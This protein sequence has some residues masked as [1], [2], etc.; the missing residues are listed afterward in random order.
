[1]A[2]LLKTRRLYNLVKH[3]PEADQVHFVHRE[4]DNEPYV[5]ESRITLNNSDW[6]AMGAPTELTLTIEPG[7]QLNG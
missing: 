6:D 2:T 5:T 4:E 1:M 3:D 7:D